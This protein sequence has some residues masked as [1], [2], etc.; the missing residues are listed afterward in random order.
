MS[1]VRP[2][3]SLTPGV[4]QSR[5][6]ITDVPGSEPA[7]S[8]VLGQVSD[9]TLEDFKKAI[10][11]AH[12]AQIKFNDSTTGAQRGALLRRWNDLILQNI[13][14]CGFYLLAFRHGPWELR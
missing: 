11:S 14:D 9:C 6:P 3:R 5:T 13:D 12:D 10:R 8:T 1:T 4:C 2:G 7:T